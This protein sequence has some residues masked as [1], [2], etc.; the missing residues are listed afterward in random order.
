MSRRADRL[1]L[2]LPLRIDIEYGD[3]DLTQVATDILGLTK[4][5]YNAAKLGDSEPVTVG[6]SDQVGEI[7]I[8][9]PSIKLRLPSFRYYI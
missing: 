5:N 4:L 2:V 7:L 3:V 6:F 8:G 1:G 9:N